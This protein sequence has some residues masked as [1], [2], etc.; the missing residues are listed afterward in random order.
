MYIYAPYDTSVLL[1][2]FCS[3]YTVFFF[4]QFGAGDLT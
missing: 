1:P 3:L 4:S 2:I